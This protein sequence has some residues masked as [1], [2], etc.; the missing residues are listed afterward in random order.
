MLIDGPMALLASMWKDALKHSAGTKNPLEKYKNVVVSF[1][2]DTRLR[3]LK[4]VE[5]WVS[6]IN[7]KI[8]DVATKEHRYGVF[9]SHQ[10]IKT[11][12]YG[13]QDSKMKIIMDLSK[14]RLQN[15]LCFKDK[16]KVPV[17]LD[18]DMIP[19][20]RQHETM[21]FSVCKSDKVMVFLDKEFFARKWCL[22][23]YFLAKN[24]NGAIMPFL[25]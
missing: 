13:Y 6:N 11:D 18:M 14:N 3:P 17:F 23:E 21:L 2:Q 15:D 20:D 12:G 25:V 19:G 7:E 24:R 10:G 1:H 5:N 16:K 4:A 22:M 8:Q 9:L